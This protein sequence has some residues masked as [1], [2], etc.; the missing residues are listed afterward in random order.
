MRTAAVTAALAVGASAAAVKRAV[1][2]VS[3]KGNGES[4]AQPSG[5]LTDPSSLLRW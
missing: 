5:T 3:V 2:T 4:N 1:T